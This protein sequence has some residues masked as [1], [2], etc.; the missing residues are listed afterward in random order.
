MMIDKEMN[1]GKWIIVVVSLFVFMGIGVVDLFLFF[2]VE[3]IGVF[4]L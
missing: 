1:M 3:S 4:Y 2:I